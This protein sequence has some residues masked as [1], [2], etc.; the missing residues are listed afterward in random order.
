MKEVEIYTDGAC[1]GNPGPGGYGTILKYGPHEKELSGAYDNTT[2]N[3]MELMA[4]IKGLESLKEPCQVTLYS[5]SKYIVDA[6]TK[7]WVTRWR[8]RGWM[9]NDKERAKN[10]DLWERVLQLSD[11][12]RVRWVWVKGHADNEFNNRCDRLAVE[13]IKH[14]PRI[15]DNPQ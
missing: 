7:G 1:S 11:R 6:M 5:D 14:K 2:N 4:V 15:M 12:H 9:R 8:S 10:V 13:A 3:R